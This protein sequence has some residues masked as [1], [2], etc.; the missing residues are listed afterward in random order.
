MAE[1][2]TKQKPDGSTPS[3]SKDTE[4]L[5]HQYAADGSVPW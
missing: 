2:Q 4:Q 1:L 5:E 3:V